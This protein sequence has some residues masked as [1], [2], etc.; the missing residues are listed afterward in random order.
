MNR[1]EIKG[2]KRKKDVKKTDLLRETNTVVTSYQNVNELSP[3]SIFL[4]I[5]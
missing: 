5:I 2:V 1:R 4:G 3:F